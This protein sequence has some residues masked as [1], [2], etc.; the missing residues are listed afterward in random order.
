MPGL[1]QPGDLSDR[2]DKG[3]LGPQRIGKPAQPP[4]IFLIEGGGGAAPALSGAGLSDFVLP[5]RPCGDDG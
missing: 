4:R 2:E 5:R 1:P 3:E